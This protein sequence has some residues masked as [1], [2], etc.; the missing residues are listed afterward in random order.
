MIGKSTMWICSITRLG[1]CPSLRRR[2]AGVSRRNLTGSGALGDLGSHAPDLVRKRMAIRVTVW[3]EYLHEVQFPEIA[4]VYPKGIHGCIADFLREA[5]MEV[6]TATLKE[7]EHGLTQ[8]VLDN[9]DVLIWWGHMAHGP[10][11]GD[12]QDLEPDT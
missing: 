6:K 9:T 11:S 12:G 5:G 7:P 2:F 1:A 10:R 8:E 4:E 3:N